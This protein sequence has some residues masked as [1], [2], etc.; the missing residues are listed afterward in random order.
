[1]SSK[2]FQFSFQSLGGFKIFIFH[3]LFLDEAKATPSVQ[4][5][6]QDASSVSSACAHASPPV[7]SVQLHPYHQIREFLEC[8][9]R[10]L[11]GRIWVQRIS[12]FYFIAKL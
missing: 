2:P 9:V 7:L 3:S 5:H 4:R 1:M 11:N 8:L 10:Q 12:G 6:L